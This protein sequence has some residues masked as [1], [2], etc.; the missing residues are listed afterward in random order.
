VTAFQRGAVPFARVGGDVVGP[1]LRAG[2]VPVREVLD[3][4]PADQVGLAPGDA[5]T[6]FDGT[7]DNSDTTLTD[8][9]DQHY[10]GNV[11]SVTWLDQVGQPHHATVPLVPGARRLIRLGRRG[12]PARSRGRSSVVG[13]HDLVTAA[14]NFSGRGC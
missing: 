7:T 5:I 14:C 3:G 11:V 2:G 9:L 10:P 13:L 6:G 8:L 12:S 4:S 1:G